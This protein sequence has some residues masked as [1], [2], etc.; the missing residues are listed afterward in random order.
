MLILWDID[1]TMISTR[2]TGR[3]AMVE[4]GQRLHGPA[5][6]AE[7]V[8]FAG[9]L[10]PLILADLL[11][12]NGIEP[13]VRTIADMRAAYR[14]T[15]EIKLRP[16]GVATAL[17]GVFALLDGLEATEGVTMGL[18]TGNFA[19]TGSLKLQAA[20]ID[21]QRFVVQVWGDQSPFNP[22]ARDHLPG[23]AL[24]RFGVHRGRPARGEEAVVIGDTP[25]DIACARAHGCRVV[26]VATGKFSR[27]ELEAAD[28]TLDD[29]GD[30][31]G[32]M[33][34]LIR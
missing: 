28:L 15:L 18:L 2:G 7:G 21:P 10:D 9:R 11:A 5:F 26:A 1:A 4:A 13:G 23:V 31:E 22:P 29:L 14:E 16:G 30:L 33:E 8:D 34:W 32:V 3:L 12:A 24:E 17:P 6:H 25:H 20:G 27:D 19:E